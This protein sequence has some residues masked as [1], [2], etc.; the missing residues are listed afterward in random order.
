MIESIN[1]NIL[2]GE[3]LESLENRAETLHDS[4]TYFYR[5]SESLKWKERWMAVKFYPK[6][7]VIILALVVLI[8]FIWI[9]GGFNKYVSNFVH[10]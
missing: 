1:K 3:E 6:L 2:R 7:A 4:S 10:E 5:K 9:S 8:I